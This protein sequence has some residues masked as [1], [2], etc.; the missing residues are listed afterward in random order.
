MLPKSGE[1]YSAI[2]LYKTIAGN[3][4]N[5][6]EVISRINEKPLAIEEADSKDIAIA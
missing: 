5:Y 2:Q 6:L 3:R 1:T 4:S